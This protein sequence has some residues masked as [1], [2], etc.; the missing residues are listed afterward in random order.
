MNDNEIKV[1]LGNK[2]Y[3]NCWTNLR[4]SR[5]MEALAGA[6]TLESVAFFD[7]ETGT[8]NLPNRGN[9][10]AIGWEAEAGAKCQISIND[11]LVLT[12]YLDS[13]EVEYGENN[14]LKFESRDVTS[15]LVDCSFALEYTKVLDQAFKKFAKW[16][17]FNKL[18]SFVAS[19]LYSGLSSGKYYAY[20]IIELICRGFG[21][22]ISYDES[23]KKTDNEKIT[24]QVDY[25]I[26]IIDIIM[27]FCM[28]KGYLPVSYGDGK[29]TLTK[30]TIV[31]RAVGSITDGNIKTARLMQ[32]NVNR[33]SIYRTMG[34]QQYGEHF[35]FPSE[36][37]EIDGIHLDKGI[38]RV[39][40]LV[41]ISDSPL[42]NAD[43]ER[44]AVFEANIRAGQSRSVEYV[45][46]GWT[47]PGS[48][49]I[50]DVNTLV[51]VKDKKLGINE[52][53]LISEVDFSLDPSNGYESRLKLVH[54]D[55][56]SLKEKTKLITIGFKK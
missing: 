43:S 27:D 46:E 32:N 39:R 23:I 7:K 42:S 44:R 53:M 6:A 48:K 30:G 3:N 13:I 47:Q 56:Y 21:I 28:K 14:K 41:I 49:K 4:V 25:G 19:F 24:Y 54:K 36:Y 33:F 16:S 55:T 5:S 22:G 29:L 40:P 11:Q 45:L 50:W 12:G 26:P 2:A 8:L 9:N 20:E 10:R 18:K 31:R 38:R 51:P 37:T 17:K 52:D 35:K 15:D 34:Q 1:L